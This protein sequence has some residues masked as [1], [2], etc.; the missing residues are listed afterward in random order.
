MITEDTISKFCEEQLGTSAHVITMIKER[1]KRSKLTQGDTE[2]L[3]KE[4]ER[5]KRIG[6]LLLIPYSLKED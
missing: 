5:L 3:V 6:K 2:A 4:G 1:I